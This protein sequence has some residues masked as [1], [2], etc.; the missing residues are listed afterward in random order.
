MA[1]AK[2]ATAPTAADNCPGSTIAQTLGA[3]SGTV[4]PIGTKT[5]TYTA[6]DAATAG[7]PTVVDL[8]VLEDDAGM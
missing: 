7:L 8:V 5:I 3:A 2:A 6:T 4:F 1:Q